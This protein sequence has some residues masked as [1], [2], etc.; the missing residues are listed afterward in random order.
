MK[1]IVPKLLIAAFIVGVPS[2]LLVI[3]SCSSDW[4]TAAMTAYLTIVTGGVIFW[5]GQQLKKQLE[6]QVLIELFKEWNSAEMRKRRA[7]YDKNINTE[8]E[9]NKLEI[10]LEYLERIGSYY[11]N[12]VL[13]KN[14]IW[15]TIGW[16]IMRYYFYNTDNI[17]KIQAKWE[18]DTLYCDLKELYCHL[19]DMEL[20]I[21]KIDEDKFNAEL[22]KQYIHFI[23]SEKS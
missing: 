20:C 16:F 7:A 12:K 15:D 4:L 22:N 18:D 9:L 13:S 10:I 3:K 14:L 23:Q 2:Y 17:S 19:L 11:K 6:L 8:D 21:R 5:Q 1:V